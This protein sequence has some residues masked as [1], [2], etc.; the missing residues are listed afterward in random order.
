MASYLDLQRQLNDLQ[1]KTNQTAEMLKAAR[2]PNYGP[3][4]QTIARIAAQSGVA[5]GESGFRSFGH[6]LH[7]ARSCNEQNWRGNPEM[8]R[9]SKSLEAKYKSTPLG[10]SETTGGDGGFL[11]PPE[12]TNQLLMRVYA[13]DIL[14]RT[15]LF[16]M[17]SNQLKIPAINETSRQD[18]SRFGGVQAYWAGEAVG[19]SNTKPN[20]Q[21][22][23][24]E[25]KKLLL[26]IRLTDEILSDS[27][28]ALE[29][30][31]DTIAAQEFE[32]VIGNA[33]VNGTGSQQ[34]LGILNSPSLVQVAA[35]VGQAAGTVT[36]SNVANMYARLHPLCHQ[37]AVWLIDPSVAATLMQQQVGFFPVMMPAGGAS[38]APFMSLLGRPLLVTEFNQTLG[39]AGDIIL[40]DLSTQ[41]T[42]SKGGMQSAVSLHVYWLT[43]EQS[44]RFTFR[45]DSRNWWQTP[46]TPHNG[47]T[48][49]KLSNIVT[50]ASR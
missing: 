41:L 5:Q 23:S 1:E 10:L 47:D 31:L 3:A 12:Y 39:T 48:T 21:Q 22:I 27:A 35:D 6:F 49:R 30:Y 43:D 14:S 28:I 4:R 17:Q 9:Y 13:N 2:L 45:M 26:F 8:V 19:V 37:N 11:V 18:G 34:P 16:P 44:F 38:G 33:I 7:V 46:L 40:T 32:F 15:T 42:G 24:L 20:F 25:L 50:L 29:T 36:L